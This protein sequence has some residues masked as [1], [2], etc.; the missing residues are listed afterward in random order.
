MKTIATLFSGGGLVEV[1]AKAAGLT[2]IWAV[3]H[4]PAIAEMYTTNHGAHVRMASVADVDP[5]ALDR[6]DILWASP[7]CQAHSQARTNKAKP[8]FDGDVGESMLAYVKVLLPRVVII[9]NVPPYQHTTVFKR[10]VTGLFESGYFVHWSIENAADYGVPQTRQRLILR[11]VRDGLVPTL[12]NKQP[13]TNWY[14]AIADLIPTLPESQ[15]ADW[16]L[17]QLPAELNTLIADSANGGR[18][19]TIREQDNPIFTITASHGYKCPVRAFLCDIQNHQLTGRIH[20]TQDETAMTIT[21]NSNRASMRAW[22][23]GRTVK[24]TVRALARFQ[25]VPDSY[26]LPKGVALGCKI[27]GNGVPCLMAQGILRNM[28]EVI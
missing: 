20:R 14:D 1:G 23:E 6:P 18:A 17:K 22:S 13:W 8:R 7:L 15:F 9:E 12:P 2:P 25:S 10:L 3:E 24:M 28:L 16:Q 27:V 5:L 19:L 21:A 11:A 4:D 26:Q